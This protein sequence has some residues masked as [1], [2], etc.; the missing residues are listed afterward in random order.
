VLDAGES[1][2]SHARGLGC[3]LIFQDLTR[4]LLVQFSSLLFSS[5]LYFFVHEWQHRDGRG[6]CFF[7]SN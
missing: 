7:A 4:L 6:R 1:S 5:E 2:A 3:L